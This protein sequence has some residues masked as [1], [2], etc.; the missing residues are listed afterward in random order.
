MIRLKNDAF[1]L[2]R[3]N[4]K[5]TITINVLINVQSINTALSN[6]KSH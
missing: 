3:N 6:I 4:H 2:I 5:C 1:K